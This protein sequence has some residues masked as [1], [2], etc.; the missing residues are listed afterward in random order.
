MFG[1]SANPVNWPQFRRFFNPELIV[2][3]IIGV[4]GCTTI[5]T[6]ISNLKNSSRVIGENLFNR[7]SFYAGNIG[8]LLFIVIL[9]FLVTVQMTAGTINPFIYF[10]F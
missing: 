9:L 8:N 6:K 10:R 3:G 4:L 7:I 2:T 1:T 5:F